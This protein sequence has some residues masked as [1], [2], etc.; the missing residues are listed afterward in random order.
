MV[1]LDHYVRFKKKQTHLI[2]Q[3]IH[4]D[5]T[6]NKNNYNDSFVSLYVV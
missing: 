2:K 6:S 5:N 4:D 1:I 3:A